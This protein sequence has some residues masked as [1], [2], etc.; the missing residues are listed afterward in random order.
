L[1]EKKTLQTFGYCRLSGVT[2][3]DLLPLAENLGLVTV[4]R[5]HPVPVRHIRPQD[6][7]TANPNT[8]SSRFGLGRF[9]FHTD[10]AHWRTPPRYVLLHCMSTGSGGRPTLL[11]DTAA[12][13]LP[14]RTLGL[15]RR[16][17]WKTAH[18]APFLCAVLA[19]DLP[20][21]RWRYDLGCMSPWSPAAREAS[22]LMCACIDDTSPLVFE[23]TAGDLLVIDNWRMLHAR[24]VAAAR[25]CD[26]LICRVLVGGSQDEE[27]GLRTT[28]AEG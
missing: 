19:D 1:I 16:A 22:E 27:L 7:S 13:D 14:A 21:A 12:F 26:R 15:F 11:V 17:V 28:V 25:D 24:G 8:L 5:R 6:A 9:P 23:W 4:D 18:R 2:D 3:G 20:P 10:A